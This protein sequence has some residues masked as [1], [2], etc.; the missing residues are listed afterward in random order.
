MQHYTFAD[1][2]AKFPPVPMP[3]TLGEDTH[4]VF[5]TENEPLPDGMIVQFIHPTEQTVADDEFTE[6]VPCFALEDTE[7]FLALVWWKA[8]LLNYEY[9]LATFTP[10]G[11]LIE[12]RV[13]AQTQV[14]STGRI[15]RSVATIDEDWVIFIA[16]GESADAEDH[17]DP[18]TSRTY[19]IEILADGTIG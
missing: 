14:L 16:E 2:L 18:T 15:R 3:V 4:H 10:K 13:I 7:R 8:S 9:V 12:R 19:D 17:F 11:E 5:S 6:Y 1:F